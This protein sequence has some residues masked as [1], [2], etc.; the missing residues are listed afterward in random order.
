MA[1]VDQQFE[2]RTH[3]AYFCCFLNF[4]FSCFVLLR[5]TKKKGSY[6][7]SIYTYTVIKSFGGAL[8]SALL[9]FPQKILEETKSVC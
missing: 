8:T 3:G 1:T 4:D 6:V 5:K 7:Y 2:N 9:F